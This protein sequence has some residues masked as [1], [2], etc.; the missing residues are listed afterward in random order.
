MEEECRG[1]GI[2]VDKVFAHAAK[3]EDFEKAKSAG[4]FAL[5]ADNL[6]SAIKAIYRAASFVYGPVIYQGGRQ[7]NITYMCDPLEKIQH[8]MV[9]EDDLPMIEEKWHALQAEIEKWC[10]DDTV[11]RE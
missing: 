5:A 7:S 3:P 6:K 11:S 10:E 4:H 2:L 9:Q 1:W 8:P